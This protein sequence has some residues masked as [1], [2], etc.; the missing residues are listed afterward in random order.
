L[1][2]AAV[3]VTLFLIFRPRFKRLY[4]PRTY[5]DSVGEQYAL[6]MNASG[7]DG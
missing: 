7:A 5:I 1:I 2:V 3:L 4:A 6:H